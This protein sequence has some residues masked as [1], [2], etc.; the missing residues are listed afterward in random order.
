MSAQAAVDSARAEL[1]LLEAKLALPRLRAGVIPRSRLFVALDRLG[2]SELTV[3]SGPAG[4]GKTVLVSSW[5]AVRTDLAKAWAT[6]DPSDDDPT[7]LWTYVSHAVDRLRPG[8]AR[9]RP[10][11][12]EDAEV[13]RRDRDRRAAQRARR[14]RRRAI[15]YGKLGVRSR[16]EAVR[17]ASVL[18]LIGQGDSPGRSSGTSARRHGSRA[19]V[20]EL[21]PTEY[22]IVVTGELGSR[23]AVTFEPMQL[24][25]RNGETE[26]VGRVEDDAELQGILETVAALG[27]SLVSVTPVT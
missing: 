24:V 4:S 5:L 17:R 13:E 16:D 27:L 2:D 7:R 1:P 12:S 25:T 15:I 18:G 23:Y 22:C 19:T 20:A 21:K 10:C 14:L 26:I 11:Q 8:L 9:S 6:L 3:I